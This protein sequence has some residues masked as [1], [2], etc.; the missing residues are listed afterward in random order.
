MFDRFLNNIPLDYLSCFAVVLRGIHGKVDICL[1]D[2]NIYS[3]LRIFPYSEAINGSITFKLTKVLQR[4]K[5]NDQLLN[6][7]LLF[8]FHFLCF[9][10]SN[11]ACFTFYTH[12]T[13]GTLCAHAIA[14]IKW[15]RL[16]NAFFKTIHD[17]ESLLQADK[18]LSQLKF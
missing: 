12:Q 10:Y 3:K 6:L 18:L 16:V 17:C 1:T 5:K 4:L 7:M 14:R 13:S 8:F 11:G 2:Y 9:Q 15:R